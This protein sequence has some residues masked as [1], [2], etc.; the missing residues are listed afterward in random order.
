MLVA[1]LLIIIVIVIVIAVTILTA[2]MA[3]G[4]LATIG[5]GILIGA[6]VG[7]VTSALITIASDLWSN[8]ALSASRIGHA[9]LVGAITGAIGGGIGAGAGLLFKSASVAV[10]FASTMVVSAAIDVG[11]QYFMGGRSFKNFS[12]LSLGITLVVTALTFGLAH[13]VA[14]ARAPAGGVRPTEPTVAPPR[15]VVTPAPVHEGAPTPVAPRETVATPTPTH[16][17]APTPTA[18]REGA[19]TPAAPHE[20]APPA[21]PSG[22]TTP[23]PAPSRE[24]PTPPASHEQTP[25]PP[26]SHEQAPPAGGAREPTSAPVTG[27]ERTVLE[28][29]ANK[30]GERLSPSE[31]TAERNIA[32]RS[33][34]HP[35]DD[36]PYV[37]EHE[38]PNGHRVRETADGQQFERCT[39]TCGIYDAEGRLIG[40]EN[41]GERVQAPATEEPSRAPTTTDEPTRAPTPGEEP[42]R[43]PTPTEEP[44]RAPTAPEAEGPPPRRTLPNGEPEPLTKR[45]GLTR[46]QSRYFRGRLRAAA[47]N[48]ELQDQI[49]FERTN[50]RL[51]NTGEPEYPDI[52]SWRRIVSARNATGNRD[53]GTAMADRV[54]PGVS[55]YTGTE[56]ISGDSVPTAGGGTTKHEFDVPGV[57]EGGA[58]VRTRPDSL[59]RGPNG[60]PSTSVVHDNKHF[61][62]RGSQVQGDTPQLQ[63]QRALAGQD[64]RHI[65]SLSSDRP[66]L[67]GTPPQPRPDPALGASTSEVVYADPATGRVT[68]TWDPSTNTWV[69]R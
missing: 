34:G 12:V 11:T 1:I 32:N 31:A 38:L 68:H 16:E 10:Q 40:T 60:E 49:R 44:A 25:T 45:Y 20:G 59:A 9:A 46:E 29:T 2:G 39:G 37:S 8:R 63:A 55:E 65:V 5:V 52:G 62:G 30:S 26:A 15:E 67:G 58:T 35:I 13:N 51:R 28:T 64:G 61:S 14:S 53:V 19:P 54:R 41:P 7:A 22:E 56:L 36:P 3:L 17:G 27:E 6:A 48:P 69:P 50:T 21:A 24:A 4:P 47:G 33:E 43:T 18:P 66:N 23:T 57:G 42:A